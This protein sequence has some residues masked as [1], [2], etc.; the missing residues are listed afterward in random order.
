MLGGAVLISPALSQAQR[1]V[2]AYFPQ[3][4][5]YSFSDESLPVDASDG[6]VYVSIDTDLTEVNVH[7]LGGNILPLQEVIHD[8]R[9]T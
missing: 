3:G 6:P 4:L 7:V 9:F 8:N 1:V 5:W 2:N